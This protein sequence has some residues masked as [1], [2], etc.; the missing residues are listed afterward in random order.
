MS[1]SEKYVAAAY[2]V[3]LLF[4]LF[5]VVIIATKLSRLERETGELA[6][7]ARARVA[8]SRPMAELLIW[9]TVIAYGEAALVYAGELRGHRR[10]STLGIWGVR[11]GWL[12]QTVLLAAQAA[13]PTGFRGAPGLGRSTCSRGSS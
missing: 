1:S 11:I 5:W 2:G 9:P 12:A 6:S 7:L 4:V 13:P 3:F 10:Y 8:A